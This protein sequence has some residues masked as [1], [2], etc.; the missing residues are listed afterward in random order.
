[1]VIKNDHVIFLQ[2]LTPKRLC[3]ELV[4]QRLAII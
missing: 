3:G 4:E 1:L 2:R